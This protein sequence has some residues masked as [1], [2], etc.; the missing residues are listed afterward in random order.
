MN[1]GLEIRQSGIHGRGLYAV[2]KFFAGET[3]VTWDLSQV[4]SQSQFDE[5]AI[6]EKQYVCRVDERLI[7]MQPPARFV[8]HS[9]EPNTKSSGDGRDVAIRDIEP[10]EEITSDYTDEGLSGKRLQCRCGSSRCRGTFS[11]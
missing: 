6:E 5:M 4:I 8:N 9:C 2:R 7:A 11:S 10:G 3:V 1:E